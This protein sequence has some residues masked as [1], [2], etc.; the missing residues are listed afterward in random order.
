MVTSCNIQETGVGDRGSK[1]VG[2]NNLTVKEQRV[3]GSR[4][5]ILPCLRFTLMGFE[6]N[7]QVG[8]PSKQTNRQ[9]RFSGSKVVVQSSEG[10]INP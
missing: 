6:R 3:C 10:M 5:G 4:H 2:R 7:Y 8:I 9:I 1:S